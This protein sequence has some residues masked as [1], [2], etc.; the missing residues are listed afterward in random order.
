[1][2][3]GRGIQG[4][5]WEV[6][7]DFDRMR[8]ERLAKV[9]KA[10]ADSGLDLLLLFRLENIRYATALRTHDWPQAHFGMAALAVIGRDQ[11]YLYTLD[12]YHAK[13]RC[14][15]LRSSLAEDENGNP[16]TCRGLELE[17]GAIAWAQ[18]VLERCKKLDISVKR[19]GVDIYSPAL[20]YAL[21]IVFKEAE[22][23]N[24]QRV[25]MQARSI[26][27]DDEILCLKIAYDITM[28][29]MYEAKEF[30]RP[31]VRECEVQAIAFKKFYELGGEWTQCEIL[32][33]P[34]PTLHP[35]EDSRQI[36][37]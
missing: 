31:G 37:S 9:R 13:G 5:D 26:K 4:V 34:V 29:G 36:E 15:W 24:G 11:E 3:L 25:M 16:V 10:V 8:K 1:M 14:P 23:V 7:V 18:D 32:F 30:L 2:D 33:V 22:F 19:V 6:R 27:T 21:P 17:S 35:T 28:A 12:Y 20:A